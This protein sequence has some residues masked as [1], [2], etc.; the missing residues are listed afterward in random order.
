MDTTNV[1]ESNMAGRAVTATRPGQPERRMRMRVLGRPIDLIAIFWSSIVA[2]LLFLSAVQVFTERPALLRTWDGVLTIALMLAYVA[3]YIFV[4]RLRRRRKRAGRVSLDKLSIRWLY[5]LFAVP[6]ALTAALLALHAAFIPLIYVDIG[7]VAMGLSWRARIL[8]MA[9]IVLIYLTESGILRP[10]SAAQ[11]GYSLFSFALTVGI[12]YSIRAILMQRSEREQLIVE[13]QEAHD[14]LRLSA[15]REIEL[16]PL[17]ERNRLA[18]EMHDTLGHALVLI[19][20]KIEAAQ[21]LQALDSAR[22]TTE[23][24]D[25]KALVRATMADLR[26]SLAGLRL[27]A[28][29]ERPFVAALTEQ[30]A[31]L[32]RRT[33]IAIDVTLADA[34]DTLDHPLQ[35]ALYRVAQEALANV[36]KHARAQHAWVALKVRDGA[37]WL[38]VSD[39][40]VGLAA[41]PRQTGGTSGAS[42]GHYGI[43]GMRERLEALAG[44]LTLTAQPAGGTLLRACVPLRAAVARDPAPVA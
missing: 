39:D 17:R 4:L 14:Q 25:T 36:A 29:E 3:W 21:R 8:P 12:V 30:A 37:A 22:A 42:G 33:G 32:S 26:S 15:A 23:L 5:P 16:A 1:I 13:L 9:L 2:V 40:G 35:E 27:S 11:L 38:E 43:L 18:R 24:E 10:A 7:I 20:V 28:L 6:L 44:T 31:E 19:A 34:A 41:T